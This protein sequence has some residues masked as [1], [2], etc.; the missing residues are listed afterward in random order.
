MAQELAKAT[1][2]LL[3]GRESGREI[4]VLF[5]PAE[6]SVEYSASFQETAAPGLSNPILQ[7]VNGNAQV[8]SM[9]LFFDTWTS[10]SR[11]NVIDATRPLT[12]LLSIDGTLHAPPR[13][14]FQWGVFQFVAVVERISQRFTMFRSD[15]T[16]VRATLTVTFKQ[17]RALAEQLEEPR[18]NSADKTKRRVMESHDSIWLM[19]AREYGEP[20]F[21]RVIARA[22]DVDDPR[23]I[24]PGQVLVLPPL[25]AD[26][27]R[28]VD[29]AAG[30]A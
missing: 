21:W 17:Y 3:D 11:A 19:A 20:R 16:P 28:E 7:F 2:T 24:E 15:G 5:N 14:R 10:G 22:N 23:R 13:V 4:T 18:R 6:Y 30:T 29:D 27:R 1:V 8:L 25:S 9:D 26:Q 12:D